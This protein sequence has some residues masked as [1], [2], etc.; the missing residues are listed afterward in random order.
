M[1]HEHIC[2]H[3][4]RT[5]EY[6]PSTLGGIGQ[7][8]VLVLVCTGKAIEETVTGTDNALAYCGN[9]SNKSRKG[10]RANDFFGK[11]RYISVG[12]FDQLNQNANV[13]CNNLRQSDKTTHLHKS[14]YS[15]H[16]HTN[17]IT[18]FYNTQDL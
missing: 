10:G 11:Q 9:K 1:K 13:A 14:F 7:G 2:Q 3:S 12:H 17:R 8:K 6:L 5:S 16:T 15:L 18:G 4:A